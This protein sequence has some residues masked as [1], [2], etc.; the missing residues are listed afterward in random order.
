[1]KKHAKNF[2]AGIL[3]WQVRRLLKR[4]DIKTI[5]A[6]GSIGKTSTKLAVAHVLSQSFRVRYQ[7]GNYNDIVTIPLVF[8]GRELKGL[9]NPFFWLWTFITNELAIVRPYPYDIVVFEVGTDGPGQFKQFADYVH[10]D[11]GILTAIT[12]EHMEY[13]ADLDEV[14]HE[15]LGIAGMSSKLLV[16]KDLVEAKYLKQLDVTPL[17]YATGQAAD[18]RLDD[19]KFNGNE[20]SFSFYADDKEVLKSAHQQISE[21][22]LYSI[23]AAAAVGHM[24]GMSAEAIDDGIRSIPQVAGR[25]QHLAGIKDSLIIDDTY[26]SSPD[27]TM[28]ALDTLY[29]LQAP[30][31]IAV[32][33]NMNE[34]GKYSRQEHTAIGNY[35]D[36]AKVDLLVTIGPDANKYLA[37]AAQERGVEVKTFDDPVSAGQFLKG[38]IKDRAVILV[39]GSQNKVFAEETLKQLLANPTDAGKL[40]RQSSYWMK[41]K[42]KQFPQVSVD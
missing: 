28:A 26:N 38:E 35:V 15:E 36:K 23:A 31:H 9:F 39:K 2:I 10:A 25:M 41:I 29:R 32:L 21:P 22:Q 16:N 33:G 17:T 11:I 6:A 34:L 4:N 12:P 30:K 3:G 13:F 40:V 24:M 1:M 27:A 20:A 18:F 37:P 42:H 5:A 19:V 14:A 8:F 7:K